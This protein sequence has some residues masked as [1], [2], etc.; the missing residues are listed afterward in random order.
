[1][2]TFRSRPSGNLRSAIT[3]LVQGA[4][5]LDEIRVDA[6][7][8]QTARNLSLAEKARI[9]AENLRLVQRQQEDPEAVG[10]FAAHSAGINMPVATRLGKYIAGAVE[11]PVVSNDDEGNPLSPSPYV[12]PTEVTPGQ[13]RLYRSALAAVQ[14]MRLG[15]GKTNAAQ[16]A[17]AAGQ[18]NESAMIAEASDAP[19]AVTGNRLVA[20]A[21]GRIREPFATNAQGTVLN[22]E[23]GELDEGGRLAGR[24]RQ[25]RS[26]QGT[27][28]DER[29]ATEPVRRS[30]L[31]AQGRLAD[32]RRNNVGAPRAP[33]G[34]TPAQI[35]KWV[36]EVAAR[37]WK[38]LPGA[39]RRGMNYEQ[40]VANV[41]T[42]F[43]AQAANPSAEI[44]QA[45]DAVMKGAPLDAVRKRFRE[46]MKFDL[47]D[48]ALNDVMI[49][50]ELEDED[51]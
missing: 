50:D 43:T 6:A 26:S 32:A 29:A 24:I 47:P 37:E 19:D 36:N 7:A 45:I 42:R 16:L 5:P 21:Y 35:E 13:E 8:A 18:G 2:P 33:V 10:T 51:E 17:N 12:R 23:T 22:Q 15:S 9:E 46:R 30:T 11:Q 28:A 44:E 25:L 38:E 49:A 1:M 4:S 34:Q 3:S 41:R 27:L 48:S 39:Q 31:S 40:H 14:G 20:A